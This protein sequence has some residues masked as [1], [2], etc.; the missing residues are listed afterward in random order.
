MTGEWQAH[1]RSSV[2]DFEEIV[3]MDIAYQQ[4][5]SLAYDLQLIL[6]TILVVVC[7]DGAY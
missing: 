7:K 3:R 4:K 1:G 6:K 5:W 2:T